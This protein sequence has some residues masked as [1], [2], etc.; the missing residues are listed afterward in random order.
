MNLLKN[1]PFQCPYCKV[2]YS[3]AVR[4]Y[5]HAFRIHF[6]EVSRLWIKCSEC[7]LHLPSQA[8]LTRHLKNDHPEKRKVSG[9]KK[10]KIC[11]GNHTKQNL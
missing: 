7:D 10:N 2:A 11:E 5:E 8:P 3:T 1:F 4:M 9:V 6:I